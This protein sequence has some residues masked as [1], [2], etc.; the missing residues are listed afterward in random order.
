MTRNFITILLL[1]FFLPIFSQEVYINSGRNFTK[2]VTSNSQNS[3]NDLL[4]S[5]NRLYDDG[6]SYA[7]G[8]IFN[9]NNSKFSYSVGLNLN[10]YNLT[11]AFD[12]SDTRYSWQT[13]YIGIQNE[14][15]MNLYQSN[16]N[17]VPGTLDLKA[18][19]GINTA[20]FVYGNVNGNLGNYSLTSNEDYKKIIFQPLAGLTL[21]FRM[22]ELCALNL[23]Y[24][25]SFN[26]VATNPQNINY[27]NSNV[28]AGLKLDLKNTFKTTK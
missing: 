25:V 8:L 27:L 17:N 2:Y 12:K 19:L 21:G 4:H 26:S 22:T 10:Q 24:S 3:V 14:L 13:H 6:K 20:A 11:Y 5:E 16:K 15:L 23:G 28:F 7:V 18:R 9:K 1:L